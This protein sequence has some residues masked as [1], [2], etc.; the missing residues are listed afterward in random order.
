[1]NVVFALLAA[2]ALMNQESLAQNINR[3]NK[4]APMGLQVNTATGNVFLDRT[5]IYIPG[6]Q[7]DIDISFA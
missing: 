2:M 1:M 4:L 5:D 7:L 3:P 6:R